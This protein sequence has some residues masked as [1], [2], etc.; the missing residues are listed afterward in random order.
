MSLDHTVEHMKEAM[1]YSDFTGR[2]GKSQDDWYDLA[3][4][5]VR[6]VLAGEADPAGDQAVAERLAAVE[7]RLK[8]DDT[9][10]REGNEGWW[11]RYV[12]P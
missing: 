10:W 9:T 6:E 4:R 12:E 5:K 8:Q 7:A 11:R 1:Y 2:T 3:G